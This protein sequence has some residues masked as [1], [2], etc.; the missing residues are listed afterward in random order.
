MESGEPFFKFG[1]GSPENFLGYNEFDQTPKAALT[2]AP[3][4]RDWRAGDPAWGANRQRGKGIIGVV[5]YLADMGMTSVYLLSMTVDGDSKDVWP[6]VAERDF[7][8]FD[9]SKLAQWNI[10]FDHMQHRGLAVHMLQQEQENDQLLGSLSTERKLYYRE[11]IA[12]F[13]AD[14]LL[15]RKTRA[16]ERRKKEKG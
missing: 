9:V 8:R 10:V 7:R 13:V 12:R 4:V 5:N 6:W 2:W 16:K 11:L 15:K 14:Q 1:P 3:H